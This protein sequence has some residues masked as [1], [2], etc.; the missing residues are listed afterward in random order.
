MYNT[1]TFETLSSDHLWARPEL[2]YL[3][4]FPLLNKSDANGVKVQ[5]SRYTCQATKETLLF[6]NIQ[7]Q[8]KHRKLYLVEC[9]HLS[10][11][12]SE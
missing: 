5:I 1:Y 4:G 6:L 8:L 3:E 11:T 7:V 10:D 2:V 12:E 9:V